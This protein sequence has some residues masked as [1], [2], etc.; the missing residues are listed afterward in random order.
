MVTRLDPTD[1]TQFKQANATDK[2]WFRIWHRWADNKNIDDVALWRFR[3][4][5]P[6]LPHTDSKSIVYDSGRYGLSLIHI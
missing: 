3:I 5:D 4:R 2:V 1:A 6:N